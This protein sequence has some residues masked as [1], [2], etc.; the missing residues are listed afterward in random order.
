MIDKILNFENIYEKDDIFYTYNLSFVEGTFEENMHDGLYTLEDNSWWF[1]HRNRIIYSAIEWIPPPQNNLA[2]VGGGNGFVSS[3]LTQQ[4][5][6]T[7][8]FEPGKH[9]I[10]NAKLRGLKNLVC[11]PLDKS[12]VKPGVFASIGLFD[13][14][15]HIEDEVCFLDEMKNALTRDGMLYVTVPAHRWLWSK[16]D[17]AAGH[18]RRYALKG[19]TETLKT[20]GFTVVYASYFFQM[21]SSAIYAFRVLP[22]RI[23]AK[24][25]H[26]KTLESNNY[27]APSAVE[28]LLELW[29]GREA[30][31]VRLGISMTHGASI[32]AVARKD[33]D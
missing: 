4:G 5:I 22:Y 30:R 11:A 28:K 32:V 16:E 7:I 27:V 6:E 3:Y 9:G 23:G 8:L 17:E 24:K 26:S 15:E 13:V 14:L 21:L 33:T 25:A 20:S 31:N 2:D 1:K 19:L 12:T 18:Y 29:L 10:K